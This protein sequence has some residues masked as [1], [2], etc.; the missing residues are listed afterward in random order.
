M[1][2]DTPPATT[3]TTTTTISPF[4]HEPLDRTIASIRL[5]KI[6]PA[7]PDNGLVQCRI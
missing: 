4:H 5:L 3:T 1:D 7:L 6:L 2:F